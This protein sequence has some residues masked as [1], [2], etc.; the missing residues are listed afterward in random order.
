MKSS[1][2][3]TVLATQLELY[4]AGNLV[5]NNCQ[6]SEEL[7]SNGD[8][9]SF[10]TRT[11]E[12]SFLV[13]LNSELFCE[14]LD[15]EKQ[16][17]LIIHVIDNN[18]IIITPLPGNVG[19]NIPIVKSCRFLPAHVIFL[20]S[21][22]MPFDI[23]LVFLEHIKCLSIKADD[24]PLDYCT[25]IFRKYT[26]DF[27]DLP[28]DTSIFD[29]GFVRLPSMLKYTSDIISG[30]ITGNSDHFVTRLRSSIRNWNS[31]FLTLSSSDFDNPRN[32]FTVVVDGGKVLNSITTAL[33]LSHYLLDKDLTL[34][35]LITRPSDYFTLN[36]LV[37]DSLPGE[38][39]KYPKSIT[40]NYFMFDFTVKVTTNSESTH[41]ILYV[42]NN[43]I[44]NCLESE[45]RNI[46][47]FNIYT[48]GKYPLVTRDALSLKATAGGI[49]ALSFKSYNKYR[50]GGTLYN[51]SVPVADVCPLVNVPDDYLED[52]KHAN[53]IYKRVIK[54]PLQ[55]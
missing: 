17:P 31:I 11:S 15:L 6:E 44:E 39:L 16:Y 41:S 7:N 21:D 9:N 26:K 55:E 5:V 12:E 19:Y 28:L 46:V 22:I 40:V 45:F 3:K 18:T 53:F 14:L 4:S 54:K 23:Q 37:F 36:E 42:R 50:T 43:K 34:N 2:L 33:T 35:V 1:L 32:E 29:N 30:I 27:K 51:V 10:V 25:G 47:K 24:T 52:S 49:T 38:C 20:V 13:E 48:S 8:P